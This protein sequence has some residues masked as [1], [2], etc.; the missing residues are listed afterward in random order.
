MIVCQQPQT[1]NEWDTFYLHVIIHMLQT[2]CTLPLNIQMINCGI[3]T[4]AI[5]LTSLVSMDFGFL[6]VAL[7][8]LMSRHE[9]MNVILFGYITSGL[10]KV[11]K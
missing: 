5:K 1:T 3:L 6:V 7:P 11:Y 8:Y 10:C 4:Y 2:T 9:K